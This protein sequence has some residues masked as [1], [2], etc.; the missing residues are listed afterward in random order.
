MQDPQNNTDIRQVLWCTLAFE[1]TKINGQTTCKISFKIRNTSDRVL[2]IS[3]N[4]TPLEL[5]ADVFKVCLEGQEVRYLGNNVN[6]WFG[7]KS[8]NDYVS[9]EPGAEVHQI[10]HHF[11]KKYDLSKPG[12]YT[13]E[14]K[15]REFEVREDVQQKETEMKI[16]APAMVLSFTLF[17][18][19]K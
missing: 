10:H 1:P 3:K 7:W 14:P 11:E 8:K 4:Q 18:G 19:I 5:F 17:Q 12:K 13:V 15:M 16:K 9:L 2:H 6:T